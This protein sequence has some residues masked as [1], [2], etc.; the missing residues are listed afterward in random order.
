[1]SRGRRSHLPYQKSLQRTF[2]QNSP[3]LRP[4]GNSMTDT[5]L[6]RAETEGDRISLTLPSI[7]SAEYAGRP[8][9]RS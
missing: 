4:E 8:G 2:I 5:L 3:V 1:M 9:T 6:T 7:D